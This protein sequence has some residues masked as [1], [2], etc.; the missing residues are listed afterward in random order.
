MLEIK[1]SIL[2]IVYVQSIFWLAHAF[3]AI[4]FPRISSFPFS[5]VGWRQASQI[6][7]LVV[8]SFPSETCTPPM[9]CPFDALNSR[10][11]FGRHF[12]VHFVLFGFCIRS[13]NS[14]LQFDS[15]NQDDLLVEIISSVSSISTCLSLPS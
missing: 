14:K 6:H 10:I 9:P 3:R 12:H 5:T 15:L 7:L 13:N 11:Q 2:I 4:L 1:S 8:S